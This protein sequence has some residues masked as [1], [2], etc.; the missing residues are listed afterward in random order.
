M[1][2]SNHILI[3]STLILFV[4]LF[5]VL[6]YLDSVYVMPLVK[7]SDIDESYLNKKVKIEGRISQQNSYKNMLF[8]EIY[9]D[10]SEI[11]GMIFESDFLLNK[12]SNYI[13]KGKVTTYD[14]KL[15]I[16][17]EKIEKIKY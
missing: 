1:K 3:K 4:S 8:L 17:I 11:L 7:I 16:I 12:S 13:F 15:E 10:S 2:L 14:K 5:I 6:F 9:D